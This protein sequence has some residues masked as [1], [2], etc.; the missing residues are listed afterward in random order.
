[1]EIALIGNTNS[2]K[3]SV[4]NKLTRSAERVGNRSSVTVESVKKRLL[5]GTT[6]VDLPGIFSLSAF[7]PDEKCTVE[8]L[9]S[10]P[11]DAVIFVADAVS[12]FRSLSLL[13]EVLEL[14]LPTLL[15][16]NKSDLLDKFGAR[17]DAQ[18]LKKAL[19][20]PVAFFSAKDKTPSEEIISKLKTALPSKPCSLTAQELTELYFTVPDTY[21]ATITADKLLTSRFFSIPVFIVIMCTVFF[22]SFSLPSL[23]FGDEFFTSRVP[24]AV[25]TVFLYLNTENFFVCLLC[26]GIVPAICSVLDFT[27]QLFILYFLIEL[28]DGCGYLSRVAFIF[29]RAMS[30]FGINGS[31][32]V[33]FILGC[34]CSC[35]GIMSCRSQKCVQ[36]RRLT[37]V[38][39]PFVPCGAKL[40]VI[41]LIGG[42][43][44]GSAWL[45][46][47]FCYAVGIFSALLSSLFLS[48]LRPFAS[49]RDF[50]LSELPRYEL[51]DLSRLTFIGIRRTL[52]FLSRALLVTALCGGVL[53]FLC[54][55]GLYGAT[56]DISESLL[57]YGAEA[58][59]VFFEPLG[60]GNWKCVAATL[61]GHIAKE[62]IVGFFGVVGLDGAFS[63]ALSAFSFLFFNLLCVPCAAAVATIHKE[64][65]SFRLTLFALIYHTGFA[66]VFCFIFYQLGLLFLEGIYSSRTTLAF[67]FLTA[68][69]AF[70]LTNR[71]TARLRGDTMNQR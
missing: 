41:S 28:L 60:T 47:A 56:S 16:L 45:C 35:G 67:I 38:G 43:C 39:I 42:Y 65:G 24:A 37:I 57:R 36:K 3:T 25:R 58:F 55:Y 6:I 2:G 54:S 52:S 4:F 69:C 53:W 68:I 61:L 64:L 40:P 11:P 18:G 8:Y 46:A 44:L 5:D 33:S 12:P 30:P 19:G 59:S 48:R 14:G 50:S 51:P 63:D 26:D 29:D 1:M 70:I 13:S 17:A 31:A 27:P 62:Q 49:K 9:S 22:L 15:L 7:S 10:T 71:L 66:Y 20:I 34:G 21:S 32:V 23:I